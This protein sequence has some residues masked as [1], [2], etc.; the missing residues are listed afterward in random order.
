[1]NN[2]SRKEYQIEIP[3]E[4]YYDANIGQ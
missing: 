3:K 2:A 1:L 4:G